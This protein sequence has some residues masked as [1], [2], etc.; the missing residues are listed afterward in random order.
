MRELLVIYTL[1]LSNA[2][3]F[4]FLG[5]VG[6][7]IALEHGREGI[8]I[9]IRDTGYGFEAAPLQSGSLIACSARSER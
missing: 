9:P 1:D 7:A 2:V 4:T 3:E 6:I 5:A 8:L